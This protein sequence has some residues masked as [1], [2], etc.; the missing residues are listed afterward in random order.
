MLIWVPECRS[1]YHMH[2]VF[3][4][5]RK[6]YWIPYGWSW[7]LTLG[8]LEKQPLLSPTESTLQPLA[9]VSEGAFLKEYVNP[10]S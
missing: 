7:E 2:M 6:G 10:G 9:C 4:E 1:V 5:A 3:V 8:L